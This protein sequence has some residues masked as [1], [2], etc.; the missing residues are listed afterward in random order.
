MSVKS[1]IAGSATVLFAASVII[2]AAEKTAG[3]AV[4]P[5]PV[6]KSTADVQAGFQTELSGLRK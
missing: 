3:A 5:A 1:I 4:T 2:S 6:A